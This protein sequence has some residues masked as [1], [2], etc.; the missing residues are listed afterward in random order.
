MRKRIIT[1]EFFKK[2]KSDNPPD[3]N[4]FGCTI[5]DSNGAEGGAAMLAHTTE[6]YL[7]DSVREYLDDLEEG[8]LFP[9]LA[10]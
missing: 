6:G 7:L 5:T 2:E 3:A 8:G 1:L 9:D 10:G 4:P